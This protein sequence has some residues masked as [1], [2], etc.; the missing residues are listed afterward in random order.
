MICPACQ[1][2]NPSGDAFCGGCGQRLAVVCRACGRANG[3][4]NSFCGQCGQ[5]L[6]GAAAPEPQRAPAEPESGERR[7]ITVLFCDLVGSTDL[8]ARL[9]PEDYREA[10]AAYHTSADEIVGRYGGH[11]A[12]HLG[13]GLLVY[14]GWPQTFDDAAE[15]AVRAGLALADA[16]AAI[17][18]GGTSLAARVGLHT[19]PVVV[20]SVGS[21]EH[22]ETLALGDAPNVA[23]RVQ[24]AAAPQEVCMTA[25][26]FRLV[27]GLFVVEERG[28]HALKGVGQPV[29]LYRAVQP[30]GVR[31]RLAAA[32]LK[33][34]TPFVNR[35]EERALLRGRFEQACEGEGQ[36]VLLAGEAG[37]GKS[38]LAQHLRAELAD[39]PHTWLETGGVAHFANTPFYALTEL[40][41][42]MI[43]W[44]SESLEERVAALADGLAAA[45][46]N[47]REALPLIAP[48]LNLPLP[49]GFQPFAGAPQVAH[50][51]L[52]ATLAAWVFGT[53]RRQP[54]VILLEDL[55]WVDPSTLELQ[56]LL[57]DQA[58]R[59]P[60]LLLYTARAEFQAPWPQRA[61]YTHLTLNRLQRR[62]TRDLITSMAERSAVL[63]EVI[64]AVMARTDGVPLFAEELTKTV[65]EAGAAAVREIP[66]TLADSLMAR[67]DRLGAAP[68]EVAQ[69]GAVCGREFDFSLLRAVH[70]ITDGELEAALSSLVEAEI[71]YV[72]GIAPEATYAFKHALVHDAAYGSLLKT[73]RRTLHAKVAATLTSAF[74]HL[75]ESHPEL[76]AQHHTLALELGAALAA[77]QQAGEQAIRRGALRE[78][79]RY[80]ERGLELLGQMPE[81]PQRDWQE[82]P[83]RVSLGKV[84]LV[85]HG[86]ADP[87]AKQMLARAMEVGEGL[88]QPLDL[89]LIV[90]GLYASALSSDGPA[91]ARALSDHLLALAERPGAGA[92]HSLAHLA[93]GLT[94]FHAGQRLAAR[95]HFETGLRKHDDAHP[96]P[97]PADVG[98]LLRTWLADALWRLGFADQARGVMREALERA[99][100]AANAEIR[101]GVLQHAAML[102]LFMRDPSTA[103]AHAARAQEAC[104]G[105]AN[106]LH[107]GIAKMVEGWCAAQ[108]GDAETGR[109]LVQAGMTVMSNI[110]QR[111][112]F[113][114]FH[115]LLADT[116]M[117]AGDF[118]GA[119]RALADAE[120]GCLGQLG[121]HVGTL[122]RRAD[123][124][125]AEAAPPSE[126]EAAFS[127]AL[128]WAHGEQARSEA[129][130]IA[131]A[132]ARWRC[133]ND[134][135]SEARD[136]LAPEYAGFTEG[137]D[138]RDLIEARELLETLG[139]PPASVRVSLPGVEAAASHS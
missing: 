50:K 44:Q 16:T 45:G 130:R 34:L 110:G 111:L 103:A 81:G 33:G 7:Q 102:C 83:L 114:L 17:Q 23:A 134:R 106:P 87:E 131:T 32:A 24:G 84:R 40:L 65:I 61:H 69:I 113:E 135:E 96:L 132:Y 125:V 75:A 100:N 124:L 98:S 77:W 12:Q 36:V 88:A 92:L 67:L 35:T 117:A 10:L 105:E 119:R 14:F 53:A 89:G 95:E 51:R 64:E 74:P 31:G 55:H 79:E 2:Q 46:L 26:T 28:E 18:A 63:A 1:Y 126:I 9:D 73:R 78:A 129:L 29:R 4:N 41:E 76:L 136:L 15:R 5:R 49:S 43:A 68:R 104:A 60:L 52:L 97:L 94:A 58:A 112:G 62:H 80:L 107:G 86:L 48:L 120:N 121:D 71:L 122:A 127:A 20:S 82:F 8:A 115:C 70:S 138:T 90:F 108:Q 42:Q 85:A 25:A 38:R 93:A 128:T 56:Q 72:R 133:E 116:C 27:S 137:F 109:A 3:A 91:V 47:P 30:S 101:A 22:R 66:S 57:V 21:G 59:E 6:T 37:I 99:A 11:V 39:I 54:L 13:D 19:G 118:D 139:V 123:L